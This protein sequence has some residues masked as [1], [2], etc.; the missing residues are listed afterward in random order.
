MFM[1]GFGTR[2]PGNLKKRLKAYAKE[3][4]TSIQSVVID[5][6]RKHLDRPVRVLCSEKEGSR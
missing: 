4:E 1:K 2:I 5:A 6:L 3:N